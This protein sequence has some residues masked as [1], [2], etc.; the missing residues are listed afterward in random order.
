MKETGVV[1]ETGKEPIATVSFHD[2]PY[3]PIMTSLVT[4][5][6]NGHDL[7]RIL[8]NE[9]HRYYQISIDGEEEKELWIEFLHALALTEHTLDDAEKVD[10]D[11]IVETMGKILTSFRASDE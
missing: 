2:S 5:Q 3:G 6:K 10:F 8:I 1:I 4:G 9:G 7:L 11:K